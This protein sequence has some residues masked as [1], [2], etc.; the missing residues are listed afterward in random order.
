MSIG[1][2]LLQSFVLCCCFV[3]SLVHAVEEV[4]DFFDMNLTE[5]AATPITIGSQLHKPLSG[6]PAVACVITADQIKT[7]GATGL[8]E[9][10]ETVS[11]IPG[12]AGGNNYLVRGLQNASNLEL[13]ILINGARI[14]KPF[15]GS[16]TNTPDLPLEVIQQ[17][18][19]TRRLG[20]ALYG[21]DAFA[22]VINIIAK[23]TKEL[24]G[25]RSGVRVGGHNARRH[26]GWLGYC[27]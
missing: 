19:V 27:Q 5:L 8:H 14:A 22:G 2:K 17:I 10:L 6:S 11:G 23:E 15:R 4:E 9:V 20:S 16:L 3:S 1:K 24:D 18:E 7:M 25:F 26:L 12:L 21:A 13:L